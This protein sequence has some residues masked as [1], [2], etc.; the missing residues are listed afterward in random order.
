LST[1]K[2]KSTYKIPYKYLTTREREIRY[3]SY[4]VLSEV[5]RG[6]GSLSAISRKHHTAPKTVLKHTGAF[7]KDEYRWSAK[8]Y[9]KLERT[10]LIYENGE[11]KYILINDSRTATII[12]KY[13][14]AVREALE[15]G[16]ETILDP[17][18]GKRI[19]NAYGNW[20][21][22]ETDLDTLYDIHERRPDEEFLEIY[23]PEGGL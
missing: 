10:M 5:R 9:D 16:N 15:T 7:K 2:P 19:K 1:L 14:C 4:T 12:G 20:H 18:K 3:R 22:L 6:K 21:T 11:E 13:L 17:F 8:R 23:S